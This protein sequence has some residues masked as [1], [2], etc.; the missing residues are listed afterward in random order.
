[1]EIATGVHRIACFFDPNRV[2]YVHLLIGNDASLLVDACCAHNP[3][4]DILPYMARIGFDP[5]QLNY[6]LTSHSDLDHQGGNA[7]M[8]AAAPRAILMAHHLDAPLISDTNVLIDERYDAYTDGFGFPK[9]DAQ[10]RAGV[11][12]QTKSTPVQR[13]LDG[14]EKIRLSADWNVEIVNTPGHSPGHVAVYDRRSKTLIAG[15]SALWSAIL[16]KDEQPALPPTYQIADS[17]LATIDRLL[18]MD[19]DQYS[20]AHWR[21]HTGQRDI[22][23]FLHDSKDYFYFVERKLIDYAQHGAFTLPDAVKALARTLGHW[24]ASNDG[25]LPQPM[26]GNLRFLTARGL[27]KQTTNAKGIYTWSLPS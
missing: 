12:E 21:V 3:D 5:A 22:H 1:M 18:D 13:T 19:I 7:P 10:G 23:G 16:H 2:S 25:A 20:P 4:Q 26:T 15:E 11:H 14:G 24:D 9:M 17:Y 8:Q 27:L 6:M